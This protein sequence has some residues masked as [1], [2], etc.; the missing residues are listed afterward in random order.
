[1]R[2]LIAF[3]TAT[4]L[5]LPILAFAAFDDVS[6]TTDTVISV[7]GM[8]LN[9][10]GSTAAIES[11]TVNADD[12]SFTLLSGSSIRITSS[13]QKKL[14]KSTTTDLTANICTDTEST[15]QYTA[16]QTQTITITPNPALCVKTSGGGGSSSNSGGGGGGS[17]TITTTVAT[18]TATTA[19]TTTPTT[20]TTT[21]PTASTSTPTVASLQAMLASL[22]AQLQVLRGGAPSMGMGFTHNLQIGSSGPD[23]KA[24]Q[25]YLNTHGYVIAQ[26]GP[27]SSGNETTLFGGKTKAAL[28]KLQKA[29]GIS[30]AVGY[31]GALTRA[32]IAAHP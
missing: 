25:V 20:A 17:T 21:V 24:L 12:F 28:I 8:S 27:G 6:L 19:T 14:D 11:I 26:S 15:L 22:M 29:A 13:E 2:K 30:P 10:Q 18:T 4:A 3:G 32:Y 7:G 5:L 16:T 1:M 9:I 23:V 31:F